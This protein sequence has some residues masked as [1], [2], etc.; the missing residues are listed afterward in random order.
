MNRIIPYQTN[1]CDYESI[2]DYII[3]QMIILVVIYIYI[4]YSNQIYQ[5][6]LILVQNLDKEITELKNVL[7]HLKLNTYSIYINPNSNTQTDNEEIDVKLD[8]DN[9]EEEIQDD[10]YDDLPDL[11]DNCSDNY[12]D[13]PDLVDN[14]S[15]NY[16]SDFSDNDSDN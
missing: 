2:Y 12:D 6:T 5:Q 15:D 7:V 1:V 14:C 3:G 11:V 4:I 16:K 10:N 8:S 13:L 9:D